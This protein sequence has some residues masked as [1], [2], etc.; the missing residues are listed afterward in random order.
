MLHLSSAQWAHCH[1]TNERMKFQTKTRC[2]C[3][4]HLI[5]CDHLNSLELITFFF[6]ASFNWNEL[7]ECGRNY[8]PKH[9]RMKTIQKY[10]RIKKQSQR[11]LYSVNV[12]VW[13]HDSLFFPHRW[14]PFRILLECHS[15]ALISM[16]FRVILL[17]E[18][19]FFALKFTW[20]RNALLDAIISLNHSR[21]IVYTTSI[22]QNAFTFVIHI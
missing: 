15:H 18:G 4:K 21:S 17:W 13:M 1:E 2:D 10:L 19:F 12:A 11:E 14:R 20:K 22:F 6:F 7:I 8:K 5:K 9:K 16:T 3:E